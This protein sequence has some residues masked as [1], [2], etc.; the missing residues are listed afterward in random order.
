MSAIRVVLADD[1]PVVLQGIKML[2]DSVGGF[3]VIGQAKN[4]LEV[5][6][7]VEKLQPEVL[8]VDLMMPGLN[9]LEVV[10]QLRQR[11]PQV[12]LVVFSM[13][14]D[15]SYVLQAL[16]NGADGYVLKGCDPQVVEEA[17]RSVAEGRRYLS[18]GISDYAI[19]SLVE[20]AQHSTNGAYDTLSARE[21][22]VLQLAAEGN[23]NADIGERLF[24]SP[25]TV[26]V[27]RASLMRK[28]GLKSQT[29]LVRYALSKGVLPLAV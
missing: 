19:N 15:E 3:D 27:H 28:L 17:L 13:H 22:E 20:K 12:R 21:R 24:I 6:E 25:R 18:P 4:G 14:A 2:L 8:L 11:T 29:D 26:E 23:T 9:G 1:H 16:K 7:M 10:R 5:V